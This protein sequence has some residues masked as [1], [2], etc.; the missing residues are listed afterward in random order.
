LPDKLLF[1]SRNICERDVC[2]HI[3]GGLIFL[4]NGC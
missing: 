3:V 1:Y 2:R 4:V